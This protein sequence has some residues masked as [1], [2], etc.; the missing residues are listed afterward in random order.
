MGSLRRVVLTHLFPIAEGGW[1]APPPT[2]RWC[3]LV[4][5]SPGSGASK[6]SAPLEGGG[7]TPPPRP[8][9]PAP[10]PPPPFKRC[11]G[12]PF[13]AHKT[14]SPAIACDFC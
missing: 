7:G 11:P 8:T 9:H 10:P 6:N 2:P 14:L 13:I 4:K 1:C 12:C 5:R 3:R